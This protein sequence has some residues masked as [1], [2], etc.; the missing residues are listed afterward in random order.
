MLMEMRAHLFLYLLLL[1]YIHT[2]KCN[3]FI[4][5]VIH[6]GYYLLVLCDKTVQRQWVDIHMKSMQIICCIWYNL[7]SCLQ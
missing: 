2:D 7:V 3:L 5:R 6:R 4:F 1:S